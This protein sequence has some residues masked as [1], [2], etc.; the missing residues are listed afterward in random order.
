MVRA[1]FSLSRRAKVAGI[2]V[3]DGKISR[4]ATI[5]V[6]RSGEEIASVSIASL[7]HFKNDVREVATGFEGGLAAEG[8]SDFEEGDIIEGYQS[9]RVR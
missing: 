9:E 5:R 3:S 2:Y 7:K 1:V 8:F 6:I 4:N